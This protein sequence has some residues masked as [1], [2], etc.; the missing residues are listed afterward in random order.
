VGKLKALGAQ[1]ATLTPTVSTQRDPEG[2]NRTAE[3]LRRLYDTAA[4][5][6]LRLDVF[7]RDLFTC[8]WPGCGKVE[9]DTSRL[10]C[11]HIVPHRGDLKLFWPMSNL[12]TLCQP[13][14]DQA[15]Q[16]LERRQ[17]GG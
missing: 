3:P 17:A 6:R 12:Q 11:D 1:L 10:R 13:H 14:H 4:W 2:H 7:E 15:K 9:G 5:A 16:R 8:Q